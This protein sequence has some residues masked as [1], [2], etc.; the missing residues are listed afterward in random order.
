MVGSSTLK[1]YDTDLSTVLK[2]VETDY[3]DDSN[4]LSKRFIG[5]P[6]ESRLYDQSNTLMSRTSVAYDESGYTASGQ[7]VSPT[8]HDNTNFGTSFNYRANQTSVTRWDATDPTNT[9]LKVTSD[10]A[11][12][13]RRLRYFAD[14]P[15]RTRCSDRLY[16]Y[17][18]RRFTVDIR[19]PDNF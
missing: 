14:R 3:S 13:Y 9:S 4:Y 18:E 1:V 2:R 16:R 19:I 7:S 11:I 12:Q 8:Q 6:T 15:A 17:V 5:L 10:N